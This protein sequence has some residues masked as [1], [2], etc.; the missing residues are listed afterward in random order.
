MRPNSE[1]PPYLLAAQA[2]S[3]VRHL[4]TRLR[5]DE[6]ASPAD[7]CRTIGALQ[8]LADD[9]V[10]VLPGLQ[11]Q[12]EEGLLAGQ[13]GAG[14]TPGEAWDKVSEVGYA[15]AQARTG[16]LLLAAELRVSQRTLGELTSS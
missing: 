14:D 15:L 9:L 11:K 2:G 6:P 1:E 7:L 5:D 3:V 4:Y 16:G 10:N 8:R 12:L 13:V